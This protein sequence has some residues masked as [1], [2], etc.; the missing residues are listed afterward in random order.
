MASTSVRAQGILLAPREIGQMVDASLEGVVPPNTSL[1]QIPISKRTILFDYDR[2]MSA[3][4]QRVVREDF[5]KMGVKRAVVLS[6]RDVLDDCGQAG[7]KPCMRLGWQVYVYLQPMTIA[8]AEAIVKLH[9]IWADHDP[10]RFVDGQPPSPA[11]RRRSFLTES[12][13]EVYLKRTTSGEW[14]FVRTGVATAG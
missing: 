1:S 7:D 8:K 6:S 9:L 4:G 10:K 5:Q 12:S 2:T 13:V 3:F 11:T 14:V